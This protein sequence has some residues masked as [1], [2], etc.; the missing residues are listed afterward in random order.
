LPGNN[1]KKKRV[2]KKQKTKVRGGNRGIKYLGEGSDEH[3]GAWKK[4]N[5]KKRERFVRF[6]NKKEGEGAAVNPPIAPRRCT[7]DTRD[8]CRARRS[9]KR[10]RSEAGKTLSNKVSARESWQTSSEHYW[11]AMARIFG[12]WDRMQGLESKKREEKRG[13]EAKRSASK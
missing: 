4:K 13:K 8:T 9:V 3:G 6:F 11:K 5:K 10:L 1:K 12:A 7:M 2:N